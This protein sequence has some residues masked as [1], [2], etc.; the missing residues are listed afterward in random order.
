[1]PKTG[2]SE[3]WRMLTDAFFPTTLRPWASPTVVVDLPSPSGVGVMAVTTTYLP[4]GRS[5]SSRVIASSRTLALVGPESSR[6]PSAIPS[7][8]AR[9]T[10]GRGVTERAISRSDGKLIK[11]PGSARGGLSLGRTDEVGQQGCVRERA[12]AARHRSD[13]GCHPAR[14]LEL[15]VAADMAIDH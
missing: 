3:G 10:I 13:R 4:R 12:D 2:P 8:P 9:S 15:D 7:S 6:P 11:S 1:M 14:R 5:A